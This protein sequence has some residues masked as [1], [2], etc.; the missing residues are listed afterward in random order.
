MGCFFLFNEFCTYIEKRFTELFS[1]GGIKAKKAGAGV[2]N[3]WNGFINDI[4]SKSGY[5]LQRE[6]IEHSRALE[7]LEV[8]NREAELIEYQNK[9][10]ETA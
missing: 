2:N 5:L 9:I 1:T 3:T 7:W 8:K 4:Y 10:N 6:L